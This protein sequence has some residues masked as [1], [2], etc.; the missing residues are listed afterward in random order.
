MILGFEH[1]TLS[2]DDV[3]AA[4]TALSK[5]GYSPSLA[6]CWVENHAAKTPLLHDYQPTM[7]VALLDCLKRTRIEIARQ[8]NVKEHGEGSYGIILGAAGEVGDHDFK[9]THELVCGSRLLTKIELAA[10]PSTAVYVDGSTS[11][12]AGERG[13]KGVS[14]RTADIAASCAFWSELLGV[15]PERSEA[16]RRRTVTLPFEAAFPRWSLD[17]HFF[18]IAASDQP[19]M[20]DDQGFTNLALIVSDLSYDRDAFIAAGAEVITGVFSIEIGGQSVLAELFR[21]PSGQIIEVVQISA[22][23]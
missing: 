15:E 6:P 10:L 12:A 16:V 4:V 7:H 20:L 18:E 8:S 14:F 17:L 11:A 2:C 9:S 13:I 23:R 1:V 19:Q 21:G 5:F 3:E 22:A